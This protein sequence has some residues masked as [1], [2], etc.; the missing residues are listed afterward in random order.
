MAFLG[1]CATS[2]VSHRKPLSTDSVWNRSP[3][4]VTQALANLIARS[5]SCLAALA[6]LRK[7]FGAD[8][9]PP[10]LAASEYR[11]CLLQPNHCDLRLRC[12]RPQKMP[13][14]SSP[15]G[16]GPR[17]RKWSVE[18]FHAPGK[19]RSPSPIQYLATLVAFRVIMTI[20]M[21]R[22]PVCI[23]I[24]AAGRPIGIARSVSRTIN[25]R[26]DRPSKPTVKQL[27]GFVLSG[28]R[29]PR[30]PAKVR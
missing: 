24:R 14:V 6:M 8:P 17:R 27:C 13:S 23:K 30:L 18:T 7:P 19:I 5:E 21:S 10:S 11:I 25:A 26:S 2:A 20:F 3:Q 12:L 1:V 29:L 4:S 15:P 28:K 16:P 9:A 22:W